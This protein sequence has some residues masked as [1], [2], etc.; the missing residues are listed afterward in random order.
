MGHRFFLL[1]FF[2][3]LGSVFGVAQSGCTLDV[4][5]DVVGVTGGVV[6]DLK[7][8]DLLAEA[9]KNQ[10]LK[11]DSLTYDAS[12][13]RILFVL[14]TVHDLPSDAR[15]A[16]AKIVERIL[17]S[18]RSVDSFALITARGTTRAVKFEQG[19]NAVKQAAAELAA[20]PR[21]KGYGP[22]V[23][24]AVEEGIGWFGEPKPG[25]SIF[26]MAMNV[27]GNHKTNAKKIAEELE[28]RHM[29]LF[30]LA[31]GPIN[32]GSTVATQSDNYKGQFSYASAGD[33]PD[34]RDQDFYPLA[35]RSGGFLFGDNAVNEQR[36]FKLTDE[37]LLKLQTMGMQFY[38][39]M[40]EFYHLNLELRSNSE[41][42]KLALSS[43]GEER[44]PK[45]KVLYP[46]ALDCGK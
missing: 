16:E 46:S 38:Q 42:W 1:S 28:A 10:T 5:V 35:M 9:G 3:V 11:I 33:M 36:E 29:R 43:A 22:G 37:H 2:L 6:R 17:T 14:D 24:D 40:A 15:K 44:L 31:L 27:G 45:T 41:A 13:R 26:L 23:L 30:G 21:E 12:P 18:A 7:P 20:D 39:V 8:A 32:L 25:D 4:P 34:Y 19:R